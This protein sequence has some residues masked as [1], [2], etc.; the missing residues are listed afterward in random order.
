M[1]MIAVVWMSY[2]PHMRLYVSSWYPVGNTVWSCPGFE[3]GEALLV[4]ECT[5][6]EVGLEGL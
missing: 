1:I 4:W 5:L 2:A 6:L 3:G